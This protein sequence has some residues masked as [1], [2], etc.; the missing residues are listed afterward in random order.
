MSL[1]ARGEAAAGAP[2]VT[3]GSEPERG[4]APRPSSPALVR[5]G[6]RW[7]CRHEF[8]AVSRPEASA[9]DVQL[10]S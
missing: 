4:V 10:P 1:P 2:T 9:P 8:D 5:H 3:D 6:G 7:W